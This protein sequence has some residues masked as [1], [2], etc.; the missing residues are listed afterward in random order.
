MRIYE[1]M[2]GNNQP[3]KSLA[4]SPLL[5]TCTSSPRPHDV[6]QPAQVQF[7]NEDVD[8]FDDH[9]ENENESTE[10][11]HFIVKIRNVN[12]HLFD[13][14]IVNLSGKNLTDPVNKVFLNDDKKE[15][16]KN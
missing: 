6:F 9:D 11:Q 4:S 16:E 14:C 7:N 5:P 10:I 2:K 12:H 3:R 1:R 13:Y 15:G 8:F